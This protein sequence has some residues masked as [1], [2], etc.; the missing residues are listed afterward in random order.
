MFGAYQREDIVYD[1]LHLFEVIN[2]M[3]RLGF[4]SA[5]LDKYAAATQ[6][7]TLQLLDFLCRCCLGVANMLQSQSQL[8]DFV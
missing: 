1:T 6:M 8:R 3:L 7:D 5:Y 2:D 4:S